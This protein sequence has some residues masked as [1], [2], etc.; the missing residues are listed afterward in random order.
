MRKRLGE[1]LINSRL[2]TEEQLQI[3]LKEQK[4]SGELLGAILFSLGFIT[5]KEL[6]TVLS[7]SYSG[8]TYQDKQEEIA[9]P[10]DIS[11]IVRQSES[12]LKRADRAPDKIEDISMAP[13]VRL[14]EKIIS[15]G[16]GKGATDIH[17]EPDTMGTR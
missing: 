14:L 17:I 16:V 6:L 3:A 11:D 13:V 10:S 12:A 9:L 7:A 8:D 4:R 2:I 5:Q 15:L 1:Q